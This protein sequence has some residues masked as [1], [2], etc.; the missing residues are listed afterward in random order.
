M[1]H[2]D[3]SVR[4]LQDSSFQVSLGGEGAM[5]MWMGMGRLTTKSETSHYPNNTLPSSVNLISGAE[6]E[7]RLIF[8][9]FAKFLPAAHKHQQ[10]YERE[11]QC[12]ASHSR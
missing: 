5:P 6:P 3:E 8:L 12:C 2:V 10:K 4:N 11:V 1:H 9:G 7:F